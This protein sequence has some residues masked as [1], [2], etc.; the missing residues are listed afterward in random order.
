MKIACGETIVPG[1]T[2][3]EKVRFLE[4]SGFDGIDLVGAELRERI[5]E[6]SNILS[7][8]K[9][10]A[11]A[12]YSRLQYSLLSSNPEEREIAIEQLKERL[13]VASQLGAVG[14]IFV[15]IFGPPKLPDLKPFMDTIQLEKALLIA[16]LKEIVPIAK[17]LGVK[18]FLEPVNKN[19]T[20]FITNLIQGLEIAEQTGVNLLTDIY[21]LIIEEQSIDS[22]FK[23]K[24]YIGCVHIASRTREVPREE[25]FE[26]LIPW[27]KAIEEV[28]YEG[29]ISLECSP[30]K[31]VEALKRFP[32]IFRDSLGRWE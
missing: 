10:K 4:E 1:S 12:I 29:Y 11:S 32:K 2:F 14:V 18:L 7:G 27:I 6:V 16:I 8:S 22:I 28:G 15:P 13:N 31:E 30:P 19:E 3:E 23:A 5:E 25:D 24:D 17:S 26:Y 20:H 9:I 21:H